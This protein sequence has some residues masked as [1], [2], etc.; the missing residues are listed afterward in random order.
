LSVELDFPHNFRDLHYDAMQGLAG[1]IGNVLW[2]ASVFRENQEQTDDAIQI[3]AFSSSRSEISYPYKSGF[4][5]RP[6][7]ER[8]SQVE[9][10]IQEVC[11]SEKI[12]SEIVSTHTG[13]RSHHE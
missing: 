8:Y 7:Q 2:K 11:R 12:Q 9:T 13:R 1:P 5:A 6:F 4:I 10:T 3:F